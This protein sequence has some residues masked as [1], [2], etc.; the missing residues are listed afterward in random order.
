MKILLTLAAL[1]FAMPA[2]AQRTPAPISQIPNTALS[3]APVPS[4]GPRAQEANMATN[5]A[6]EANNSALATNPSRVNA[7]PALASY[8]ICKRGQFDDCMEPGNNA[9]KKMKKRQR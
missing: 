3:T 4:T 9:A 5:S 2:T 6:A 8:P 1:A 7:A